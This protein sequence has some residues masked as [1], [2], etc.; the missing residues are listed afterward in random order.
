MSESIRFTVDHRDGLRAAVIRAGN[1]A[2]EFLAKGLIVELVIREY[3]SQRSIEQNA[4]YH[5]ICAEIAKVKPWAGRMLDTEGWKRLLVD[6]WV[7]ESGGRIGDIV[8][9]LDGMSVVTLN[10]STAAMKTKE[11]AELIEFALAFAATEQI[12]VKYAEAA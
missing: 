4:M 7:R 2:L 6:A 5:G 10:K 11:L 12:H 3:R 9:S 8:P 1:A